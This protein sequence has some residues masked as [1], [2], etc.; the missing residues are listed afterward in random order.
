M[1]L[2]L[3]VISNPT[4]RHLA[5]LETLPEDTIITTGNSMEMLAGAAPEADVILNGMNRGELLQEV[6]PLASKVRWV[7]SLSAGIENITFPELVNSSVPLTNSRG[8]FRRSLA[9]FVLA[10]MLFFAKD[11]RRMMRNQQAAHWE[12]FDIEELHDRT[13][14][15]VGYGEIGRAAAERARAFGMRIVALRRRPQLCQMDSLVS[16][17][18]GSDQIGELM[19]E[20]DYVLAAAPLTPE[21]RGLIGERELRAMKPTAVI[22]NVGRGP[23]IDEPAL[24]RALEEQWIRGAALDVFDTEPLPAGHPF[25]RLENILL[26]PHCADHTATWL[27]EA[28]QFFISN[29]QRFSSGEPLEN[30]CNKAAGY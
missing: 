15:I 7:H 25:W 2:R 17:S 8:V 16:K 20:S 21:T 19:A 27:E 12:Q 14:G 13:L 30:V 4:A 28:M 29:F 23:V 3:L 18:Y 22:M 11:L 6:W 26:S 5:A 10:S 9:E 24:I 1:S